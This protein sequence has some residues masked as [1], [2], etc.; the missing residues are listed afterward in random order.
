MF[1][2]M[3]LP[4]RVGYLPK[5]FNTFPTEEERKKAMEEEFKKIDKNEDGE[6]GIYFVFGQSTNKDIF[7]GSIC[8]GEWIGYAMGDGFK[9]AFEDKAEMP[10]NFFTGKDL[11]NPF[12][13]HSEK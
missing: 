11:K 6:L 3:E 7:L 10:K 13:S 12:V 5:D 2:A 4:R 8:L 1:H 9:M